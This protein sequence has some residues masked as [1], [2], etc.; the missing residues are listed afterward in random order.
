VIVRPTG[1]KVHR[2]W[3]C[4]ASIVLP[5][6]VDQ[7]DKHEPARR[8]GKQIHRYLERVREAGEAEALA[9]QPRELWA[10]LRALDLDELPTQL[11]TE[12]AY[13]WNWRTR[14]ARM[15]GRNL[16]R[17]YSGVDWTSEI[18]FTIDIVGA[19]VAQHIGM[20]ADYKTGH[21]KLPAPDLYGQTLL[22]GAGARAHLQLDEVILQLIYIHSDG[23]HHKVTRT[24]GPWE[25]DDFELELQ[26]AMLLA[27]HW[28]AELAAGR[29]VN[30]NE[31][32]WCDH[33][34]AYNHCPAKVALVR[35]IPEE[36]RRLGVTP[37]ADGQA[38]EVDSRSI[39]VAKAAD[40]WVAIERIEEALGRIKKEICGFAAHQDIELPDG[41]VIGL[42]ETEK[43]KLD[44]KLAAQVL[45]RRYPGSS[46]DAVEMKCTLES[47][48]TAI[49]ARK[50]PGQVAQSKKG[51]GIVDLALAELEQVGGIQ[52]VTTA[53]VKPHVPRKKRLPVAR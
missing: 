5:Q 3:K 11:W 48:V 12:V 45:E 47:F 15:L 40:W 46:A 4:P 21:S 43:R 22:A 1:S 6:V 37:G 32:E 25:L 41:R 9:E 8:R 38:L 28:E 33:C 19:A 31:G 35:A 49:A 2:A 36:L 52:R 53:S 20:V 17:D 44:G 42:L 50:Q 7:T 10:L 51:T 39:T 24:V 18:P 29:G 34:P 30:V 14:S 13:A 27:E 23:D 16:D 26:A